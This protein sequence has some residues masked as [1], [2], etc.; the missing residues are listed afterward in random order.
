MAAVSLC[1]QMGIVVV[2]ASPGL[3]VAKAGGQRNPITSVPEP[4]PEHLL[5][6][7]MR[8]IDDTWL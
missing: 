7:T 6:G 4:V 2:E 8:F 3:S 1:Y 5:S